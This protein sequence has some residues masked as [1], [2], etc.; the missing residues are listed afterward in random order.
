ME[1]KTVVENAAVANTEVVINELVKR[2]ARAQVKFMD[3][4]QQQI[5]RIVRAMALAGVEK[6]MELA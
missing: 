2:A 5:D 4:D 6:H 1:K 3:Y